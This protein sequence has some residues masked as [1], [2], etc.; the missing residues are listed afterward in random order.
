MRP[1]LTAA[2]KRDMKFRGFGPL[3]YFGKLRKMGRIPHHKVMQQ[4]AKA[5]RAALPEIPK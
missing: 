5:F 1:A 3:T 4:R 2:F